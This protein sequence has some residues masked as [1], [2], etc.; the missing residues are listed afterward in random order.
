MLWA[1]NTLYNK[2]SWIEELIR[3]VRSREQRLVYC[4]LKYIARADNGDEKSLIRY[5]IPIILP[6]L[7]HLFLLGDPG[8]ASR[9]GVERVP[10]L[11]GDYTCP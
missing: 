1:E 9:S 5:Q 3:G 4:K 11:Y 8:A 10:Y 7:Y 2:Q 6:F